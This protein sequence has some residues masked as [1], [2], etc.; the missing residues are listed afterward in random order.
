MIVVTAG[1]IDHGKTALVRALT[2][3]DT[4]RLPEERARGI[5][6]DLGFAFLDAGD[7]GRIAFV[8]VP[9]HEKLVRTML[10]G[11][12]GGSFALLVVAADEGPRPQ[13]L[14]HLALLDLLELR[15]GA[16]ALTKTDRTDAARVAGT[17]EA[18]RAMLA[19]TTLAAAPVLP[20]SALTGEGIAALAAHLAGAARAGATRDG[21]TR[22]GAGEGFRLAVD[23]AFT[24]A[25][26]GLVATG[27]VHAGVVRPGDR[28][29]VSP[30]GTEARV[31]AVHADGLAAGEARAGQRCAVNLSG[32]RLS[33]DAL[34]R[35]SWVLDPALHAPTSCLDLRLVL[36][37]GEPALPARG[38]TVHAHVGTARVSGRVSPLGP[39]ESAGVDG[40]LARLA[41]DAPV[42]ALAGDRVVLR[43]VGARR[44]VG[45][46]RVLDPFGPA[47]GAGRP[48]RLRALAASDRPGAAAALSG[49]LDVQDAV[50]LA[51]FRLARNVPAAAEAGLLASCAAVAV[52]LDGRR[53]AV[54]T[55]RWAAVRGEVLA[56]LD[57]H[58]AA[59]PDSFGLAAADIA[60]ALPQERRPLVPAAL[61]ALTAEG[62]LLRLG[63]LLR[64]A[65]HAVRLAP[66]DEAAWARL[67][68]LLRGAGLDPPRLAQLVDGLG[69]EEAE[70]RPLLDRLARLGRLRAVSRHYYVLPAV[71][72]TLAACAWSAGVDGLLTVGPFRAAAGIGRNAA[73]AVLEFFDHVGFTRRVPEGRRLGQPWAAPGRP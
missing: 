59:R 24:L 70:L 53:A 37:A 40:R 7:A 60:A 46:G 22:S 19:A 26:V 21:A 32:P 28:V 20:C 1:H 4:D 73:M 30:A 44:T 55:A 29:V 62:A 14:E 27:T 57:A 42:G 13:T 68:A 58:A 35:G 51:P 11:A 2:G 16:V 34:G 72:D 61:G 66:E 31:R 63:R 36:A 9:G 18:V 49:L 64:P 3:T 6:I 17:A 69:I 48:E 50:P 15:Q 47:R 8:D 23:R 25:G 5:T 67:E 54:G 52:E 43:D 56:V 65:G 38:R 41:L 10:A 12:T 45:G 39:A 71:L 33:R